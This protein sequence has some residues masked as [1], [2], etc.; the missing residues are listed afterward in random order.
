M[1]SRTALSDLFSATHAVISFQNEPAPTAAGIR[2]DPS[3]RNVV[4]FCRISTAF[5]FTGSPPFRPE[6][7]YDDNFPDPHVILDPA[8]GTYIAYATNTGGATLP[9]MQ[10][11]DLETW[12]AKADLFTPPRWAAPASDRDPLHRYDQRA[13]RAGP[14]V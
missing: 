7:I 9:M 3:K 14:A 4:A 2:S 8:S 10:S 13:G 11:T 5:A 6:R 1:E 12:T